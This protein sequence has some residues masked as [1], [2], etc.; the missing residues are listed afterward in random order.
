MNRRLSALTLALLTVL[1][2]CDQAPASVVGPILPRLSG[3]VVDNAHLHT[4]KQ[5]VR[6]EAMSSA[7][8]RETGPQY[9]IV[10]LPSLQGFPI[11][12]FGISLGRG[13]GI[14][15]RSRNDGV[16]LIV[17]PRERKVR[18]EVG[19]GL[20]KRLTDPFCAQIIRERILPAFGRGDF[21]GGIDAG[22]AAIVDRLRRTAAVNDHPAI[23]KQA[24]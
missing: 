2:G 23:R 10:T 5:R 24:A 17:A 8:E 1:A 4:G 21:A 6:L 3:R 22:S 7:L 11:E 18:I 20:E 19:Y 9:V 13:W 14:G 15:S 12:K 16:L